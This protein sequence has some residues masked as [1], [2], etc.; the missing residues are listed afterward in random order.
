MMTPSP[1][2]T[3]PYTAKLSQ[4]AMQLRGRSA[5]AAQTLRTPPRAEAQHAMAAVQAHARHSNHDSHVAQSG[6]ALA[7]E[8]TAHPPPKRA[9]V[10]LK[11]GPFALRFVTEDLPEASA[12][13]DRSDDS[14]TRAVA[15]LAPDGRGDAEI[16]PGLTWDELADVAR[17]KA[18]E[19]LAREEART[20]SYASAP[21]SVEQEVASLRASLTPD[22]LASLEDDQRSGFPGVA[23]QSARRRAATQY[24]HTAALDGFQPERGALRGVL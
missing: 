4:A 6:E 14:A 5:Y 9:A 11:L 15:R 13:A 10:G 16:L 2:G 7:T 20:A 22:P 18:E 21:Y 12:A 17:R 23:E 8:D 19:D 24:V 3:S 1:I